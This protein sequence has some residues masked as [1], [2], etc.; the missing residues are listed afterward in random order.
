MIK[1]SETQDSLELLE[2]TWSWPLN[3]RLDFLCVCILSPANDKAD[4]T[5]QCNR[6][7]MELTFLCFSIQSVLQELLQHLADMGYV[8]NRGARKGYRPGTQ[9]DL[10]SLRVS[11]TRAWKTAGALVST[12]NSVFEVAQRRLEGGLPDVGVA[13]V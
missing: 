4:G 13:E 7:Y 10:G 12:N 2:G 3:Q 1:I 8:F 5:S 9:T 6:W 11:L